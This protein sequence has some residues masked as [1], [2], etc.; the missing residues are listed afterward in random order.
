MLAPL[1]EFYGRRPIYVIGYFIYS[2]FSFLVAFGNFPGLLVGRFIQGVAG[3]AFLSVAGGSVS[4]LWAG[5]KVGRPMAI[6]SAAPFLGPV[7]G[8]LLASFINQSLHWRWTWYISTIWNFVEL[9][10]IVFLAPETY[11]PRILKDKAKKLRKETGNSNL[12]SAAE[13]K[14]EEMGISKTMYVIK[15]T[16]RP[17]RRCFLLHFYANNTYKAN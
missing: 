16:A 3:S 13:I 4:D 1:S 7:L 15:S 14:E 9:A 2:C 8:P 12:R 6:Y 17:F 10:F 11:A 5:P